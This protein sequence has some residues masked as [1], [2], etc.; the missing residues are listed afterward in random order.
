MAVTAGQ[1]AQLLGAELQ[2]E[3]ITVTAPSSL[4]NIFAGAIV[5]SSEFSAHTVESLNQT[6][7]LLAIVSPEFA[8]HLAC[9]HVI[10]LR[11]RLAFARV[12]TAFF[13]ERV[14][15]GIAATA[16][17]G[18]GVLLG[19]G[20]SVGEYSVVGE[21]ADIQSECEIRHHVVVGPGTK[22]G[23]RCLIKSNTVIGGEGFGF[24]YDEQG[25]PL[26]IPHLGRVR[27]GNNVEIGSGTV[28]AQG[29]LEDTV[30]EDDVKIDDQVFIAHNVV[31]QSN[32]LIIA[33][34]EI[35]GS[36]RVGKNV[37]I[38][39]NATIIQKVSI[40]DGAMIGIGAVVTKDVP[41]NVVVAGNPARIVGPRHS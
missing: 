29:T 10:S 22:I 7:R 5:F 34:A 19:E 39:P 11:P 41:P 16:R 12:L 31:V 37:W 3:D 28:I 14:V 21:D 24:E 17:M 13:S 38:G 15:R 36:V 25:R 35:S 40:G 30:I 6:S 4:S 8:G 2:G 26:R 9:P 18:A 1:V 20:V 33:C 32:T 23:K 27:I